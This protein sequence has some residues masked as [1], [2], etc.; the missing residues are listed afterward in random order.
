[1]L[2]RQHPKPVACAFLRKTNVA[3]AIL[4]RHQVDDTSVAGASVYE[5]R[6][7]IVP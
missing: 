3:F 5:E 4:L 6:A 2:H 1:M 7:G